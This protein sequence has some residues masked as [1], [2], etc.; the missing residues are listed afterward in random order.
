MKKLR[1]FKEPLCI[2]EIQDLCIHEQ[3]NLDVLLDAMEGG[4]VID[5]D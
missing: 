5:T 2:D 4:Y 1:M 3:K